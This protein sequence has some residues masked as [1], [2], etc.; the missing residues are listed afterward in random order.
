MMVETDRGE[1]TAWGAIDRGVHPSFALDSKQLGLDRRPQ[2][3]C[4]ED[5]EHDEHRDR[6][7]VGPDTIGE[8]ADHAASVSYSAAAAAIICANSSREERSTTTSVAPDT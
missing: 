5:S 4:E 7:A 8:C 1:V 3:Q 6:C 2:V